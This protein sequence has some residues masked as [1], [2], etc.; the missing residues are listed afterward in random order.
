MS[1]RNVN[2][3]KVLSAIM[4]MVDAD[5]LII[6]YETKAVVSVSKK[7]NYSPYVS[8]SYWYRKL[9]GERVYDLAFECVKKYG[10]SIRD[11]IIY[12]KIIDIQLEEVLSDG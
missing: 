9:G 7:D 2:Y 12:N 11:G 6:W 10:L 1:K 4:K 3:S 5:Y 8:S